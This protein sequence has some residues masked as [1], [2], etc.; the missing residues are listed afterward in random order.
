MPFAYPALPTGQDAVRILNV[1]PGDFLS[2]LTGTLVSVAF[3]DRPKYVALSYTW[4]S[5]YSD[6]LQ[7]PI[8]PKDSRHS[9]QISDNSP[10]RSR[11]SSSPTLRERRPS[12]MDQRT[13]ERS[14]RRVIS[15]LPITNNVHGEIV[16]NGDI[17]CIGHNLQLALL[18][19]R[20]PT[21]PLSMWVDAICIN[22]ADEPERNHQVSMMAFIYIRATKVVAWLGT[23]IYP[24]MSGLFRSMSL[25]WKAGHTQHFGAFL[26]GQN[27]LRCSQKPDQS[28]IARMFDSSY[29]RRTWIVQEVCLPRHLLLVYGSDIWTHEEFKEWGNVSLAYLGMHLRQNDHGYFDFAMRLLETRDRRHSS[30]MRLENLIER[31]AKNACSELRDRIYGVV[32]CANDVRPFAGWDDSANLLQ[33]HIDHLSSGLESSYNPQRGK[34][35][36]RIDYSCTFYELWA[37]VISLVY[38]QAKEIELE[39]SIPTAALGLPLTEKY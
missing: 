3:C 11:T 35:S 32:G 29:W 22:Q 13:A 5:S 21:H 30:V 14:P 17:F 12:S 38:F 7:L 15:P 34:G 2:P 39:V 24:P 19:L 26:M 6:N 8:S 18:H 31:F 33:S 16:L 27:K 25:E 23:K 36:L 37:R 10:E 4:G 1:D 20:S 28:T 9:L